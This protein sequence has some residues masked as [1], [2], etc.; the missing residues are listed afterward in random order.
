MIIEYGGRNCWAFK[1]WMTVS[2]EINKN[3]PQE[4]GFSDVNVVPA[5]C[6]E[7]GNASGKSCALRVL[8]FIIDF[9]KNS[10]VLSNSQSILFD[11]YFNNDDP[12]EF[13]LT[14]ALSE[15]LSQK[16]TYEVKL[17]KRKVLSETLYTVNGDKKVFL[18]KR[19][20]NKISS[21]YFTTKIDNI[22]IKDNSSVISTL[23]QYGVPEMNRFLPFFS[24]F[25]SNV[26]YNSTIDE[27]LVDYAAAYYYENPDIHR[28]VVEQLKLFDTGIEEVVI[29]KGV[30]MYGREQ[31][32]SEFIHKTVEGGQSLNY[33]NQSTGTK[34]LY[35]RLKDF[36]LTLLNGGIFIY[37]E[38]GEHLHP[39]IVPY[40]YN[41]FLDNESNKTHAQ[42]IFTS[43]YPG[44]MDD[45]KKYRT[46][47]FNKEDGES[48]C[49]RVDE[50]SSKI[51]LR[52]DRSLEAT[53]KTGML[54]GVP[55]V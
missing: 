6:F 40:L 53:Y 16:Y 22:I 52:N 33:F 7:G 28:R 39:R 46:Y 10:F 5:L 37:D 24:N 15:A 19:E 48:Y 38:L 29:R 55:N 1:E 4:Y 2:F 21:N 31:F 36:F 8:S 44:I 32:L 23:F 50:L 41:Y 49:Y 47:L 14:F 30:D 13:F 20:N 12:A 35:N 26:T 34:L 25:L 17:T 11:T 51:L 54:G 3:V 27:Q 45:M 9:C 43:H 18:I 42:F